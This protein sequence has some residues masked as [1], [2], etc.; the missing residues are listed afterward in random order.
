VIRDLTPVLEGLLQPGHLLCFELGEGSPQVEADRRQLEQAL[1]ALISNADD[2]LEAPAGAVTLRTA[3]GLPGG[4]EA[5]EG[6]WVEPLPGEAGAFLVLTV[7]DSGSGMEPDVLQRI[8]D[9]FFT[10]RFQGRGMGLASVLGIVR[11]HRGGLRVS[12][13]RG[14]GSSFE[15]HLPARED[16]AEAPAQAAAAPRPRQLPRGILLAEDDTFLRE[17]IRDMLD[18][19]GYDRVFEVADGK[20]AILQYEAH[21]REI[22]LV[23]LDVDMPSMGG[24]ETYGRLRELNPS[25]KIVFATGAWEQ[26]PELV[27]H[28]AHGI[29]GILSKPFQHS[30]LKSLL[31]FYLG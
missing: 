10:T 17:A 4:A 1:I 21:A 14:Q 23:L 28:T 29:T 2:A 25:L 13:R 11:A 22:G 30:E 31:D 27:R 16:P 3:R 8:F 20:E 19:L 6:T 12:S 7:Q 24:I 9:P 18:L 26:N 15:L 5:G